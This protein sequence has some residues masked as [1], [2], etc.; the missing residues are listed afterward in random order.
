VIFLRP[1]CDLRHGPFSSLVPDALQRDPEGTVGSVAEMG[2]EWVKFYAPY[3]EWSEAQA[4]QRRKGAGDD[5][6]E[7]RSRNLQPSS[8]PYSRLTNSYARSR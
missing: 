4:K 7:A 2:C 1:E 8:I 6:V 3:L 5:D